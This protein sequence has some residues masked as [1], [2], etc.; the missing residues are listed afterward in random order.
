MLTELQKRAA[1]AI[2]NVFETGDA[3]GDYGKVTLMKGD[4][5]HLT[6]GRSQ[7]TL[8]SGN[9]YLLIK[10]YCDA[11]DAEF[12]ESLSHYLPRLIRRD[13][14]LD[15]ETTLHSILRKAGNDP[16]M[17]DVQDAFFDRAYWNPSVTAADNLG[18]V[19]TL[20]TAVVYDSMVHGSW[21]LMRDKTLTDCGTVAALGER[22]WIA[23]YINVR[24]NWLATHKTLI[25][26][27]TVYRMDALF[28]LVQA[29]NWDLSLPFYV[30][31]VRVDEGA[32]KP[33]ILRV[34]AQQE[35]ERIL[36]LQKPY[37]RGEDVREVQNA[38]ITR[39]YAL[40]V[41]SVFGEKTDKAVEE[42]QKK[43]GLT[44][45]GVVGPVTKAA[46]GLL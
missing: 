37:M 22:Q 21:R 32:L 28:D 24:R 15:G 30:R 11:E 1:Q 19:T 13:T 17:Q 26:R 43:T 14:T 40:K 39:G 25:L 2:I 5:G 7:T 12:A 20:G 44:A 35:D 29:S 9:L 8:S 46:L 23:K 3:Q 4:P 16:I 38:L 27:K 41:D 42:F 36:F 6:Y 10:A 33:V 31:G 18:I 45:D 34:S